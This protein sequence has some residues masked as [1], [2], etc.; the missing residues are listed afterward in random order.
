MLIFHVVVCIP[1]HTFNLVIVALYSF[2]HSI[3]YV[4]FS[5]QPEVLFP[6]SFV[7]LS[8]LKWNIL[9]IL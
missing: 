4:H 2:L 7:R 9:G 1:T 6:V 3:D 5:F 8:L